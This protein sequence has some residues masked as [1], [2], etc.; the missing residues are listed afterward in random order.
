[1]AG[2]MLREFTP[3]PLSLLS[4]GRLLRRAQH[5][6]AG[7]GRDP[8]S[9]THNRLRCWTQPVGLETEVLTQLASTSPVL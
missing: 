1:M 4:A 8:G 2:S 7:T 9:Q 5:A 6:A 3:L